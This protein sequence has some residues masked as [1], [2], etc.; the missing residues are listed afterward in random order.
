MNLR[1]SLASTAFARRDASDKLRGRTCFT[2][3]QAYQGHLQAY[4]LR[5][6]VASGEILRLNVSAARQMPGVRAIVTA[7]DA[8]YQ[9]GIGVADQRLFATGRVRYKGEPL[10]A[11]AAD[12]LEQAKAAAGAVEIDIRPLPAVIDMAA[13]LTEGAPLVHPD[14][15]GHEVVL[16]ARGAR[17]GGNL[18]WESLVRRGDVDAAFAR[19]DVT[20][21]ESSFAV[22]RQIHMQLEPRSAIASYIDGR[23]HLVASTQAPWTV[24]NVTARALGL[25]ASRVRVTAPAVG[26]GF[27][28]K[29]GCTIE[30]YAAAL[31]MAC[32]K[33]VAIVPSRAEEMLSCPCRENADIQIR[34]AVTADGHIVGREAVVLMDCGAYG[35]EQIYLTT[36][37]AHTLGSA[38][39]LGSVRLVSRAV[40][41]NTAPNGAFRACNGVYNIFA[42]ESH[43]DEICQAIGMDSFEFRR[44]NVLGDGDLGSTGQVFQGDVLGPMLDKMALLRAKD[45]SPLSGKSSADARHEGWLRGRATTVGTWFVFVG[46]SAATVNLNP[47]GSAT[48][49]TAGVE[50]GQGTMMQSLPQIVAAELG[51]APA[52][53]VVHQADTD[54]V[55]FDV[56]VGGGRTTVS[57]GAAAVAACAEIRQ[58]VT[59]LASRLMQV[60]SS[61]LILTQGRVERQGHPGSGMTLASLAQEA[62]QITGPIS[63]NGSFTRPGV[64]AL[65]GCTSGHF[66][67]AVDIPVFAVHDCEVA[68]DPATGHVEVLRYHVVQDVGYALNPS[69]IEGQIQGGVVQGLGYALHEEVTF[70]SDGAIC[71]NGFGSYRVPLAQDV[72]PVVIELHEGAPSIGPWGTKGAGEVPILNVGATIACAVSQAA[73]LRVQQLPLTPPHV[74]AI[75][76]GRKLPLPP[77]HV[78]AWPARPGF[79]PH[80]TKSA[81]VADN[82]KGKDRS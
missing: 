68:V 75:L 44:R 3:D 30:P 63:G 27:G 80:T 54:A 35:G 11:I 55:G 33:S 66:L 7:A 8:P 14:W 25:P 5:A 17:R 50:I 57:L 34:S 73:G 76:Q 45:D 20:I 32:G 51:I 64:A 77:D 49:V 78:Q 36:M 2:V 26:G 29:Y 69:A 37:T 10:V 48:L 56:G 47:D 53:V 15:D 72:I 13:A 23:L 67:E 12:T 82:L 79:I 9:F 46:P 61:K 60:P 28:A 6:D 24:K 18:A 31:A 71:Q 38:Y 70:T 19:P 39:R 21:V 16:E 65:E 62:L 1:P 4:L 40:Y 43:T 74:L 22:G 42:L 59:D 81:K 52:E 41:T 58:K